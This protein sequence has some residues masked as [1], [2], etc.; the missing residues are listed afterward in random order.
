MQHWIRYAYAALHSVGLSY[1]LYITNISNSHS[2]QT[3]DSMQAI[4]LH[5]MQTVRHCLHNVSH[6][7]AEVV[8][9][10]N[11]TVVACE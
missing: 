3:M 7:R 1:L 9:D 5:V 6:T 8:P 4:E 2:V 10:I 11:T